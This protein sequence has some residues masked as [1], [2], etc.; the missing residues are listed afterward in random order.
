MTYELFESYSQHPLPTISKPLFENFGYRA[1][2]FL[3]HTTFW[4]WWPFLWAFL[5]THF[6]YP[7]N[8][9]F[10]RV[11]L[12]RLVFCISL[13]VLYAAT[14]AIFAATPRI[15]L[16]AGLN[17]Q[18]SMFMKSVPIV[19]QVLPL[20]SLGL[21]ARWAYKTSAAFR[22][23]DGVFRVTHRSEKEKYK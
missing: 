4:L 2:S 16:L 21:I 12:H 22:D 7:E 23:K 15:L 10:G 8:E 18:P 19:S 11:Y 3:V 1:T 20:F 17:H 6:Y 9:S 5:H 14:Y 13:A